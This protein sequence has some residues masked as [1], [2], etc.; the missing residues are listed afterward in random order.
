MM[1]YWIYYHENMETENTSNR[2]VTNIPDYLVKHVI[3]ESAL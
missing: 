1:H 2:K 3:R